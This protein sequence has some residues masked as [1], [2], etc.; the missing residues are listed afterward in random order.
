MAKGEVETK[1]AKRVKKARTIGLFAFFAL[2]AFFVSLC[3]PMKEA[4]FVNVSQHQRYSGV[5][6]RSMRPTL[7]RQGRRRRLQL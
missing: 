3:I 6:L 2:F 4:N 1:K 5:F 7:L